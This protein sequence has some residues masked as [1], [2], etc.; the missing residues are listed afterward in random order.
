MLENNDNDKQITIKAEIDPR[1]EQYRLLHRKRTA[2]GE[3]AYTRSVNFQGENI[4][5]LYDEF[6]TS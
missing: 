1:S 6:I 3:P 5:S 2:N 4:N